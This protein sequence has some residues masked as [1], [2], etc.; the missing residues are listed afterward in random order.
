MDRVL[1]DLGPLSI[2]PSCKITDDDEAE[3][4][5]AQADIAAGALAQANEKLTGFY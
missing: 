3:P 5:S 1:Q 2:T 4:E